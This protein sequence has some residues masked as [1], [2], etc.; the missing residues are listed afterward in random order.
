LTKTLLHLTWLVITPTILIA[1][2]PLLKPDASPHKVQFI[3]VAPGVSLEVVDWGGSG[4][5]LVFL[6]GLGNTAHV[7]DNFAPKFVPQ[8]RAYGITRR[9][10]GASSSPIP[11]DSS[12]TADQLGD[13]VLKVMGVL[14]VKK[15][16][17]IG[18]SI[19]GE[20]LSSIEV[21]FQIKLQ[22]KSTSTRAIHMRSIRLN[23]V[24]VSWTPRT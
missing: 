6:A 10:F 18:H 14:G 3:T 22:D 2:Q 12:Y 8:Y 4:P 9:G 5:R 17:L 19:A 24:T 15:P 23:L 13:D 11:N 21:D 7:F 1:Q 20:E 16:V